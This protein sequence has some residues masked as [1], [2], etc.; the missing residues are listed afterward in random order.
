MAFLQDERPGGAPRALAAPVRDSSSSRRC[1]AQGARE[2]TLG[3]ARISGFHGKRSP[4]EPGRR[5]EGGTLLSPRR[6]PSWRR[7]PTYTGTRRLSCSL[8]GGRRTAVLTFNVSS[9]GVDGVI[10]AQAPL[11]YSGAVTS[12]K[13]RLLIGGR[14]SRS[15]SL[16][17]SRW[18][19]EP[20]AR[21]IT[22]LSA[23]ADRISHGSFGEPVVDHSRDEIGRARARLRGACGRV[24]TR[25]T[26][27]PRVH[28]QRVARAAHAAVVARRLPRA[29]RTT[30]TSTRTSAPSSWSRCGSRCP[31]HALATDLLDLSRLDAGPLSRVERR[32]GSRAV[33]DTV[34][35]E[36]SRWR[37]RTTTRSRSRPETAVSLRSEIRSACSRLGVSW[38]RTRSS[39]RHRGHRCACAS[40]T[41][42]DEQCFRWRTRGRA[43]PRARASRSSSASTGRRAGAP[44]AAGWAW[45]SRASSP[46]PWA[47]A[48]RSSR[49]AGRTFSRWA[50]PVAGGGPPFPTGKEGRAGRGEAVARGTSLTK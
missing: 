31:A 33:A 1:M 13:R 37:S 24:S 25:S 36:F 40:T 3:V 41:V 2:T 42:T 44:P 17:P 12:V 39:T 18:R 43:S 50:L 19:A 8:P 49:R 15:S 10:L 14:W 30:R 20:L 6:S 35:E 11:A 7:A 46:V 32:R 9:Q 4:P 16:V 28:R 27:A 38:S 48:S 22:R 26:R 23:A 45:R 34:A 5:L 21:R 47:D 29:D